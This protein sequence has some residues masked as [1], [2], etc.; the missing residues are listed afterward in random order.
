MEYQ[1]V[2]FNFEFLLAPK[3]WI[4]VID[5]LSNKFTQTFYLKI[6][7]C[8][9]FILFYY[10]FWTIYFLYQTLYYTLMFNIPSQIFINATN[11]LRK[12]TWMFQLFYNNL[13]YI[14]VFLFYNWVLVDN[15]KLM[16]IS[17]YFDADFGK[18]IV[19]WNISDFN[20]ILMWWLINVKLVS[21]FGFARKEVGF[22]YD[23]LAVILLV[24]P[25]VGGDGC[26]KS[27]LHPSEDTCTQSLKQ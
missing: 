1:I 11:W 3:I 10:Y 22:R 2:G 15:L 4:V 23:F 6:W 13:F 7:W 17:S 9:I 27:M 19:L 21:E 14:V 8:I 5:F 18:T 16:T 12:C 26:K 24:T 20:C 25:L